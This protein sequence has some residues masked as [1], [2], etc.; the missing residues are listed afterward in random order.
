MN[1]LSPAPT[2]ASVVFARM[3]EFA[4]RPVAEQARLRAQ[5]E[6]AMG[7]AVAP[8]AADERIVLE[9]PEGMALAVLG[10]P[11]AALDAAERLCAA[12][13]GLALGIGVNHGPVAPG[14]QDLAGDG[15]HSAGV[16][17]GFAAPAQ[18]LM[19]RS[20][21]E[22]LAEAAPDREAV[23]RSAGVFT[24]PSLR[25]HELYSADAT[26]VRQRGRRLFALGVAGCLGLLGAG[27][28]LRP[29]LQSLTEQ[30][31]AMLVFAI[32]PAGEIYVDGAYQGKSPPLQQL[33]LNGGRHHLEV[34]N[35]TRPPLVLELDLQPGERR[36]VRHTFV[37]PKKARPADAW[38]QWKRKLGID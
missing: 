34:R 7:M 20:F 2:L 35:G 32:S 1:D 31:A 23:L 12:A 22:A 13:A 16:V 21:R 38:R 28:A 30:P 26:A 27:I 15:V 6:A 3:P 11:R 5:L 29:L 8:M 33:Q 37:T 17:A 10:N 25:S 24:D 19:S 9:A 14:N 18:I 36:E 4:R